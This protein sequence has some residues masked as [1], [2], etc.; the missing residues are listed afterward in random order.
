M[1]AVVV[2]SHFQKG[3]CK[4]REKCRYLHISE[5]CSDNDCSTEACQ[6]RHPTQCRYF[7]SH[8]VC[9][10]ARNCAYRHD[11]SL[12]NQI[13]A[14]HDKMVDY[15]A[16]LSLIEEALDR[17]KNM[18]N[19]EEAEMLSSSSAFDTGQSKLLLENT[20]I[21]QVDGNLSTITSPLH[22]DDD[23]IGASQ[24]FFGT[25][26]IPADDIVQKSENSDLLCET[27]FL[28]QHGTSNS[29]KYCEF[30]EKEF[31][32]LEDF[33]VHMKCHRYICS[34]CLDYFSDMV[35]FPSVE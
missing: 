17:L 1:A 16:K 34:N 3:F 35:W 23:N 4:Y 12:A 24:N 7:T 9:K 18:Y 21:P 5:V 31:S 27:N 6:F 20:T 15:S 32:S 14:I 10:F 29:I 30:C 13:K 26:T 28:G 8:G 25:I 33:W 2:C 22:K 19:T 11:T